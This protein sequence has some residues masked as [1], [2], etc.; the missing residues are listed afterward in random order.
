MILFDSIVCRFLHRSQDL[1]SLIPW[2]WFQ[3]S[4]W[5]KFQLLFWWKFWPFIYKLSSHR[6][7]F[8]IPTLKIWNNS[9]IEAPNFEHF[10]HDPLILRTNC[11]KAT[12]NFYKPC[13]VIIC[14]CIKIDLLVVFTWFLPSNNFVIM[15]ISYYIA[16]GIL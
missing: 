8:L 11:K 6:A 3:K 16:M 15:T 9:K 10:I 4:H 5:A 12:S 7:K 14:G 13:K 1:L 2:I